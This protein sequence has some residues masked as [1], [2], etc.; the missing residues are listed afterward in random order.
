MTSFD[1]AESSHADAGRAPDSDRLASLGDY[2]LIE[3]LGRGGMGTVYR[4]EHRRLGKS[5]AIKVLPA[6]RVHDPASVSRFEREMRAVGQ[7][8]HPHIVQAYDAREEQG[9]H[10]LVMQLVRGVDVAAIVQRHGPLRVPDACEIVRQAALGLQYAHERGL[11]HRDIKPS[12]LLLAQNGIVKIL[13]MGLALLSCDT[14]QGELTSTG[15][16]MGTLDYIAPEQIASTHHV[17]IRA[18][19][20]SLGCTLFKLLTGIAPFAGPASSNP[21]QKMRAHEREAPPPLT[22]LRPDLPAEVGAIVERLLA[23]DPDARY[24]TPQELADAI[25][26]LCD[27]AELRTLIENLPPATNTQPAIPQP[28]ASHVSRSGRTETVT[29]FPALPAAV[30]DQPLTGHELTFRP[31]TGTGIAN[32]AHERKPPNA[33]SCERAS[34]SAC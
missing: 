28:T 3:V 1:T 20:Y 26:P 15:E 13:D 23:K 6:E 29:S 27:G 24:Q 14:H 10:F 17:D 12:N 5:V 34:A 33:A 4:A 21:L 19:L 9:T 8:D 30:D 32:R 22:S 11:V 31:G 25:Q 7:L 2:D 16:I 18:D